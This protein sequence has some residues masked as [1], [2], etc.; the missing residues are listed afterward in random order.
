MKRYL[1]RWVEVVII[2]IQVILFMVLGGECEDLKIF[3]ISKLIALTLFIIN[4]MIL[5]KYSRYMED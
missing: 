1:K 5:F 2:C 4:S 3:I